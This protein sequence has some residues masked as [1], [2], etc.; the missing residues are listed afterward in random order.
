MLDRYVI[1]S[2][3]SHL[4]SIRLSKRSADEIHSIPQLPYLKSN[5]TPISCSW[6]AVGRRQSTDLTGASWL[7][8]RIPIR[9]SSQCERTDCT[10]HGRHHDLYVAPWP[11]AYHIPYSDLAVSALYGNTA[12]SELDLVRKIQSILKSLHD[13]GQSIPRKYIIDFSKKDLSVSRTGASLYLM[14][15][16]VCVLLLVKQVYVLTQTLGCHSLHP[17][18]HPAE[19]QGQGRRAAPVRGRLQ[20]IQPVPFVHGSVDQEHPDPVDV[21]ETKPI[22]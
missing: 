14:L 17:A 18:T 11:L 13:T 4:Q 9:A 8:S 19:S 16:Q 21:A 7:R 1:S 5:Q 20:H 12:L 3:H 10:C 15:Y 2:V 6:S 22:G